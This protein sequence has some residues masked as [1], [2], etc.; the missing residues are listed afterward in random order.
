MGSDIVDFAPWLGVFETV[1]VVGGVPL[2]AAEHRAELG[3]AMEALGITTAANFEQARAGL[4]ALSGRWRWVVMANEAWTLFT[5]EEEAPAEPVSLTVS[6]QRVGSQNWDARFK[7]VS[8]LTH[9]QA[10]RVDGDAV[11]LNENGDVASAAR[12]NLFWRRGEKLYTP[13]HESGCRCGVVRA[14]VLAQ[15]KVKMG[16]FPLSDLAE[17][18]E[19][20]IT[21]SMKGILSVKSFQARGLGGFPVADQLRAV[22]AEGMAAQV[23]G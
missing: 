7:T 21:N 15:M 23:K 17:A 10:A 11:L 6:P 4:P 12:G 20:F 3:R 5:E 2:F 18:E 14:F 22:Y 13:A 9:A 19:I 1:R 16:H 8:Y